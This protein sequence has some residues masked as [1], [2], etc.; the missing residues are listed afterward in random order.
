MEIR[1]VLRTDT[2]NSY[3]QYYWLKVTGNA[4]IIEFEIGGPMENGRKI[5]VSTRELIAAVNAVQAQEG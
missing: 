2:E 4:D 5:G 1:I 3:P